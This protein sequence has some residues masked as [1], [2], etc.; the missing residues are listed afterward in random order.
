MVKGIIKQLQ[1]LL[2]CKFLVNHIIDFNYGAHV[3][4]SEAMSSSEIHLGLQ[5]AGLK[6][7]LDQLHIVLVTTRKAGAPQTNLYLYLCQN[8]S[9]IVR[10]AKVRISYHKKPNC[11]F[12][13][14]V[15]FVTEYYLFL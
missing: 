13:N 7:L 12:F 4:C 10:H 8:C 3:A 15:I 14:I 9:L 1:Q 6:I 11:Y 2:L 5:L